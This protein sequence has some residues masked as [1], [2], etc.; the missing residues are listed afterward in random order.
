MRFMV[1]FSSY[2]EHSES[3]NIY[4]IVEYLTSLFTFRYTTKYKIYEKLFQ[5]NLFPI[6]LRYIVTAAEMHHSFT[7]LTK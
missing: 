1:T 2:S 7:N 4:E 5:I 6:I 3:I